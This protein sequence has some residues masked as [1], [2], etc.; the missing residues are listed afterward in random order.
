VVLELGALTAVST[1]ALQFCFEVCASGTRLS[2]ARL[3]CV[4]VPARV[5]CVACDR[6]RGAAPEDPTL[7]GSTC[8]CG[9]AAF[10]VLEG[11]ELNI[12]AVEIAAGE[13]F[14]VHDMRL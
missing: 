1:S 3:R 8:G 11:D 13:E 7:L 9:E 10:E 5:R 12:Q 14:D 4:H 2:R 6:V